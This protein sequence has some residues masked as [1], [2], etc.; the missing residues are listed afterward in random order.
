MGALVGYMVD[1]R[2][3][4]ERKPGVAPRTAGYRH[5]RQWAGNRRPRGH[6]AASQGAAALA[7]AD[8]SAC[9][10]RGRL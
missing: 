5:R 3:K 8:N 7:P 1:R 6:T 9:G 4:A 10:Y 2:S